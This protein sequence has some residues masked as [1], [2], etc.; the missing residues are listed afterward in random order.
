M[1]V[2]WIQWINFNIGVKI[3]LLCKN[4]LF[5]QKLVDCKKKIDPSRC[6]AAVQLV[7]HLP[8]RVAELPSRVAELPS[9]VAQLPSRVAEL[10]SMVI[11]L[12]SRIV[13]LPS[14]VIYLPFKKMC[15]PSRV[16]LW[17]TS[18]SAVR[19]GHK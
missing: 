1:F 10:T 18:N 8:S 2:N 14:R 13:Q 5:W 15:L 7:V 9:R 3:K 17:S 4:N 16:F 11:Y 12:S 6:P 19:T